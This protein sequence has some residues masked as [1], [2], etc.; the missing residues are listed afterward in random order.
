M[1]GYRSLIAG[2]VAIIALVWLAH[3]GD[4]ASVREAMTHIGTVITALVVR[5]AG[6][7]RDT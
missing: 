6:R 2:I 5:S 4:A 1:R 7:A 3:G